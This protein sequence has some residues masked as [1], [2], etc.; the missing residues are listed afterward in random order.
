MRDYYVYI[1]SSRSRR[2][3][4]GVTNN[5]PVRLS[6]HRQGQC[7]FTARY[8]IQRLVYFETT[9]NVMAA[10][11]REKQIKSW[12]R[13]KKLALIESTNPAWDDLSDSW[14]QRDGESAEKVE[15]AESA[16]PSLCS[17]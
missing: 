9:A 16:D 5:L 13:S 4:V 7:E 6:Q 1:L 3:Y 14:L 12:R 10:I 8:K 11:E 15:T 17:G 2:L